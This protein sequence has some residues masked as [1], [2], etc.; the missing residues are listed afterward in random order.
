M[1]KIVIRGKYCEIER[2]LRFFAIV[3][4]MQDD[5]ARNGEYYH[6]YVDIYIYNIEHYRCIVLLNVNIVVI[7]GVIPCNI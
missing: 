3:S 1:K 6:E 7:S 5:I 2:V 4:S